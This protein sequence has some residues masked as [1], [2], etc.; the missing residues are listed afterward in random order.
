MKEKLDFLNAQQISNYL[1]I[2][3]RTVYHL[4]KKG[5][6]KSYRIGGRWKYLKDDIENLDHRFTAS[7]L[8]NSFNA[9]QVSKYLNIPLSTTYRLTKQ[10]KIKSIKIGGQYKYFKH[11]IDQYL[12]QNTYYSETQMQKQSSF[13]ERR[14]SPRINCSIPCYI[15]VNISNEKNISSISNISNISKGGTFIKYHINNN[16]FNY[17]NRDDPINLKFSINGNCN[18]DING[19]VLRTNDQGL[20]IKFKNLDLT[21]TKQLENYIG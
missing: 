9:K 13:I 7:K 21:T 18:L 8:I 16:S 15:K 2:P 10:G 19:R 5:I 6:I 11:D 1:N 17:I 14:F 20:A 12:S 3:I 4:S